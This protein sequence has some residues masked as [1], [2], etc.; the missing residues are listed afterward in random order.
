MHEL[1]MKCAKPGCGNEEFDNMK[2]L[3]QHVRDFHRNK[4]DADELEPQIQE[5]DTN[6]DVIDLFT[7]SAAGEYIGGPCNNRMQ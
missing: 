2:L 6:M 1:S 5:A 4:V 3:M 7:N